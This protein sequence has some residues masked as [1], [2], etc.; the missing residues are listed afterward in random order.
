MLVVTLP[1]SAAHDPLSFVAQAKEAG[2]DLLEIRGDLTPNVQ[3]FDSLL[4][5][6]ISPR[7][8]GDALLARFQPTYIDLEMGET[9]SFSLSA[10]LIRSF[11]DYKKTPDV[12]ELIAIAN[13]CQREGADIIKIVTTINSYADLLILEKLHNAF[14]KEQKRV[15]LGMGI[16]AHYDRMLSPLRNELT[17]TYL[18][19]DEPAAPGQVP[20][21]LYS[22][23]K[24]CK[25][26][27]MF[28]IL[29]SLGVK[30]SSPLI[31]NAFFEAHNID[32]IFTM[33]LSDDLED[34]MRFIR[35]VEVQG[36]SITTPFKKEIVSY[37]D[38]LDPLARE[39]GS[40]NTAIV[41]NGNYTGYNKDMDGVRDGYDFLAPGSSVAI[42][43]S[44]G[45]VP[46][47]IHACKQKGIE[48][49]QI[50]ARSREV[51]ME[52]EQK[53]SIRAFDLSEISHAKPDVL[54]CAVNDDM[55]L[56]IPSA[57]TG[58]HAIDLRYGKA[59]QFLSDAAEKGYR[60]HDGISMLLHQALGQF[61]CFTGIRPSDED[62]R[63]IQSLFPAL[64]GKQ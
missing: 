31:H 36:L 64:Y 52:L 44:G 20:I 35:Q 16:R 43:G 50:F 18:D 5:L 22:K 37:F 25:H 24:H 49:I 9:I 38:D 51:R 14:S 11:H 48:D 1:S 34:V 46:A 8:S 42:L 7:N 3:P 57:K 47:V 27:R 17:Y 12:S 54:I 45:V 53:F 6:I 61:E 4:P 2:A 30:S 19:G 59:T 29:G 32:A 28:G 41:K 56:D 13:Q 23:T 40:V 15:I 60:T 58:A 10:T 39:L 62:Y 33:F 63:L 21:S 26:P 55:S